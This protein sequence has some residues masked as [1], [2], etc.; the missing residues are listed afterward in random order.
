MAETKKEVDRAPSLKRSWDD[1]C[2][3]DDSPEPQPNIMED[4]PSVAVTKSRE[5]NHDSD[6]PIGLV[7]DEAGSN[8]SGNY[9]KLDRRS[10]TGGI[11][12]LS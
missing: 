10:V 2:S 5:N 9:C 1:C 6:R 7:F 8:G 4:T 3:N 11:E 12:A